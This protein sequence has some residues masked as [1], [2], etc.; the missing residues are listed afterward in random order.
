MIDIEALFETHLTVADLQ[1]SMTFYSTTLG[2]TL[3]QVFW[4]EK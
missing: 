2:L 3:A 4:V 1:R